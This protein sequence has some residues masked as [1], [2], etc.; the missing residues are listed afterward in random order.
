MGRRSLHSEILVM[1]TDERI[2]ALERRINIL[3]ERV[4]LLGKLNREYVRENQKLH[5]ERI[6]YLARVERAQRRRMEAK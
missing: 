5:G 2:D 4:I 3:S 6:V 1:T